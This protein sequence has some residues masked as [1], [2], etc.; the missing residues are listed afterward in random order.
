M[1]GEEVAAEE[2]RAEQTAERGGGLVG[3]EVFD[4]V[5]GLVAE[6]EREVCVAFDLDRAQV[7]V[8]ERRVASAPLAE[9][10][11]DE[12]PVRDTLAQCLDELFERPV[13]RHSV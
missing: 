11:L 2:D 5:A 7:D 3:P 13:V 8:P 12:R 4:E 6:G 10:Q 9:R 1:R